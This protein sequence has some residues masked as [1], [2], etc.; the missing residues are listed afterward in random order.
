VSTTQLSVAAIEALEALERVQELYG[1]GTAA[2]H[3]ARLDHAHD[4]MEKAG[5]VRL[6]FPPEAVNEAA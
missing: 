3:R 6:E 1:T 2:D 5:F 4:L